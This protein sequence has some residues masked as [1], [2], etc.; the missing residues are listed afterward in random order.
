MSTTQPETAASHLR[1]EL[2][3]YFLTVPTYREQT[4]E[5]QEI[6]LARLCELGD[7]EQRE[8]LQAAGHHRP[9]T[10]GNPVPLI[11]NLLTAAQRLAAGRGQPLLVFPAKETSFSF[12]A[13]MHPRLLSVGVCTL[14]RIA[15][16]AAPREPIWIRLQEQESCLT[17][18]ATAAKP[19]V[20]SPS[21][22]VI[23]EC[24]ALHKGSPAQC[25]NTY[26]FSIAREAEPT[27][28]IKRAL[29]PTAEELCRDTLSPVWTAFYC[30][31]SSNS[32]PLKGEPDEEEL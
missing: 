29:C 10:W 15:Y 9:L 16:E 19:P 23:Q 14:L 26:G 7:L 32:S 24:A 5:Q 30:R 4:P 22:Q 13:M 6:Y 28:R 11:Q 8:I 1:E 27:E 17:I 21:W 25:G 2:A 3:A 12:T 31:L 18:T 20:S